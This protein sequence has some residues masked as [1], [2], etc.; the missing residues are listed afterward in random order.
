MSFSDIKCNLSV[1]SWKMVLKCLVEGSNK[2]ALIL[3]LHRVNPS[4]LNSVTGSLLGHLS[5]CHF[6]PLIMSNSSQGFNQTLKSGRPGG[7]FS[8]KI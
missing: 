2:E 5:F 3:P 6:Q 1:V 8:H 7:V 4:D